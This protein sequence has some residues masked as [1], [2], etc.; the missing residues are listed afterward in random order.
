MIIMYVETKILNCS[1]LK[2]FNTTKSGKLTKITKTIIYFNLIEFYIFNILMIMP[3]IFICRVYIYISF[4]EI[5]FD[6]WFFL[7]FVRLGLKIKQLWYCF[8]SIFEAIEILNFK[9]LIN[10]M[11]IFYF[12]WV[13]K[14]IYLLLLH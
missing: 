11:L 6:L 13:F 9:L 12:Y 5:L 4:L 14:S 2:F 10:L 7:I 3:I 8:F 1:N